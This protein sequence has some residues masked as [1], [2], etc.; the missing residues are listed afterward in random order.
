MENNIN[1]KDEKSIDFVK[2]LKESRE[3]DSSFIKIL[4]C[5][6]IIFVVVIMSIFIL[7]DN[8]KFLTKHFGKD[9]S[10]TKI[11]KNLSQSPKYLPC[12]W[13]LYK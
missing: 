1:N 11:F 9:S 10:I 13:C 12:F 2:R 4:T 7:A 6:V 3:E 5:M 8:E